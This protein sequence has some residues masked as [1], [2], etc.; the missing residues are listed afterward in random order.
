MF[1]LW[2][3]LHWYYCIRDLDSDRL[4]STGVGF[5]AAAVSM[6]MGGCRAVRPVV[7]LLPAVTVD[8]PIAVGPAVL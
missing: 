1:I 4:E 3:K 2:C 8:I 6:P 7:S 5:V